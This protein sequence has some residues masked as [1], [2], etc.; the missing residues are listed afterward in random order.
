M[1]AFVYYPELARFLKGQLADKTAE[2]IA[3]ET[4]IPGHTVRAFFRG[5]RQGFIPEEVNSIAHRLGIIPEELL[6]AAGFE[7]VVT[8]Q[9]KVDDALAEVWALLPKAQRESLLELLQQATR[10]PAPEAG[11]AQ[12]PTR[13]R[14]RQGSP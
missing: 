4:G 5:E 11:R 7:V 8:P 1:A 10:N 2:D 9:K 13:R 12:R 14:R 3:S 6:R